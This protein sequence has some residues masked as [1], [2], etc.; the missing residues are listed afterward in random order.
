MYLMAL[1]GQWG[2]LR[3]R[4]NSSN[5]SELG[6]SNTQAPPHLILCYAT[7]NRMFHPKY[8]S[9]YIAASF[10]YS[11]RKAGKDF[12]SIDWHGYFFWGGGGI[13]RNPSPQGDCVPIQGFHAPSA[14]NSGTQG[15]LPYWLLDPTS[16]AQLLAYLL[17]CYSHS[18][19]MSLKVSFKFSQ[20]AD[21]I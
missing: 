6:E 13:I 5:L 17:A 1:L 4:P 11:W 15:I 14:W 7:R 20:P 19:W 3:T 12:C 10:P 2:R 16:I 8:F 18:F 9:I 21:C